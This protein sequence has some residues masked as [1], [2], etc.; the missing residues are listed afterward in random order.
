MVAGP[1]R[2]LRD[3]QVDVQEPGRVRD[4]ALTVKFLAAVVQPGGK[5]GDH[6][7][8]LV[9]QFFLEAGL[10]ALVDDY[11]LDAMPFQLS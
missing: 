2:L 4:D 8:H 6:F 9:G 7:Q 10:L 11:Y 3:S 1:V 5:D